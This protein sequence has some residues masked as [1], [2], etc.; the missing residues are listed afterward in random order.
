MGS[1]LVNAICIDDSGFCT[2]FHWLVHRAGM[3]N[4]TNSVETDWEGRLYRRL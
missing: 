3:F 1:K 2:L 4:D